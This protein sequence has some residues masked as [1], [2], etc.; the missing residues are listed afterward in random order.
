MAKKIPARSTK[1]LAR[2]VALVAGRLAAPD[3]ASH[4]R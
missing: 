4:A 2:R 3:E 1:P